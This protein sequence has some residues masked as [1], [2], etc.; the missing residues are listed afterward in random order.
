MRI[1]PVHVA[2]GFTTAAIVAGLILVLVHMLTAILTAA[3]AP[4]QLPSARGETQ[5]IIQQIHADIDSML[6][7]CDRIQADLARSRELIASLPDR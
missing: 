6:A 7:R 4:V 1:A 3:Y 5:R 2:T